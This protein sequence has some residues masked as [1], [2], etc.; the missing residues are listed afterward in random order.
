MLA[1]YTGAKSGMA[2]GMR[3]QQS[4]RLI[5]EQLGN[6]LQTLKQQ[7]AGAIERHKQ[8]QLKVLISNFLVVSTIS[9]EFSWKQFNKHFILDERTYVRTKKCVENVKNGIFGSNYP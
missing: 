7:E 1:H 3:M 2:S 6:I 8:L 4:Q 5:E 9:E